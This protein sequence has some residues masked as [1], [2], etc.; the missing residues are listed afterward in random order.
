V[1]RNFLQ[2]LNLKVLK[3][4]EANIVALGRGEGKAVLIV[5][6]L[7]DTGK[8]AMVCA[9][10]AHFATL[11]AKPVGRPMVDTFITDATVKSECVHER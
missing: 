5:N 4:V 1:R 10:S 2:S 3:V 7:V 9:A 6:D 8:T 11:Y